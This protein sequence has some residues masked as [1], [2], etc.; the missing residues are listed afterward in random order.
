MNIPA[1][2]V[3]PHYTEGS[4]GIVRIFEIVGV[5]QSSVPKM[6]VSTHSQLVA[7]AISYVIS[8]LDTYFGV[9]LKFAIS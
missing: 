1:S 4:T 7:T 9:A 2:I 5:S 8:Y 3:T 6:T